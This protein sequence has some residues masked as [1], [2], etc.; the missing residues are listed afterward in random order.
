ML[1]SLHRNIKIRLIIS[2][3]STFVSNMVFPFMA[4]YFFQA[5]GSLFAGILILMNVIISALAGMIGG[6]LSDRTGRKRIMVTAQIIEFATFS[7]M[8]LANSNWWTSPLFTFCMML[9]G[10]L[11]GGLMHPAEEA[12]LI[13]V[14]TEENRRLMYGIN[15]WSTNLGMAGG[16]AIGGLFFSTYRFLLFLVLACASLIIL[17]LIIFFMTEVYQRPDSPGKK[18]AASFSLFIHYG[19]VMTDRLFLLFCLGNLLVLSLEFQTTNYIAVHLEKAFKTIVF[20]N[21]FSLDSYSMISWMRIENTLLVVVLAFFISKSTRHFSASRVFLIGLPIYSLGYAFQAFSTQWVWLTAAVLLATIGEL[22]YV[23]VGQTLLASLPKEESRASYM[24]VYGLVF[25]GAKLLGAVGIIAGAFL[26]PIA[27]AALFM[28]AGL[29]GMWCYLCV[30]R[31][32]EKK[33]IKNY[34]A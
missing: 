34:E 24:A 26:S 28:L 21:W 4:I 27:M 32:R 22:M 1:Q 23:P 14:S 19:H 10:N 30:C 18:K 25:Q 2:F 6:Y 15:Y 5:F 33:I 17:S 16:A 7:G 12:M 8:A 11:A 29:A 13:D 3:L 20:N 9:I 31:Q